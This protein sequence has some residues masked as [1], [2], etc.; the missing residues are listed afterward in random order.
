MKI[1]ISNI[2]WTESEDDDCLNILAEQ[3]ITGLEIAPRKLFPRLGQTDPEEIARY[4]EKLAARSL[5]LIAMQG[6]LFGQPELTLFADKNRRQQT[7]RYLKEM[8]DFG[9]R[10]GAKILVFGSPG[11]RRLGDL[12][13]RQAQDIARD[14]FRDIGDYAAAHALS[15]CIE[16]NARVYQCD[17]IQTV[18][19]A[20]ELIAEVDSPGFGL[21]VDAAVMALSGEDVAAT[22]QLAAGQIRHFHI[23]E[24][25]LGLITQN[26]TGH[27]RFA[28]ALSQIGY[29][30]W[31]SIEMKSGVL[32][33]NI[34][35]V[36]NSLAFVKACYGDRC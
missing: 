34:A 8:I 5:Q 27:E 28:Q 21:H 7:A 4:R 26:Q 9:Q 2:A 14:F 6:L 11:N 3:G 24:P 22:I 35:A 31:L 18:P 25:F 1:A 15:F 19:E 20:L 36:Q 32:P 30:Q 16:P 17:F 29:D 13:L 23:S 33:S 12:S 10:L